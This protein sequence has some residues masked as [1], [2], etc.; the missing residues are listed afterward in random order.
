MSRK[1]EITCIQLSKEVKAQLDELGTKNSTYEGII[2]NLI[3]S[4]CVKKQGES[5]EE[6]SD[7]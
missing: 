7:D 2:K 1:D 3:A 5:Q 6:N 4:T